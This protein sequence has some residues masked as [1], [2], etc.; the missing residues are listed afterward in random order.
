MDRLTH[1]FTVSEGDRSNDLAEDAVEDYHLL[2]EG[3]CPGSSV[4]GMIFKCLCGAS[5]QREQNQREDQSGN[6]GIHVTSLKEHMAIVA[7]T[8]LS[9]KR[10]RFF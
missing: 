1:L 10:E 3:I 5:S 8:L 9:R 4:M 6:E 7:N 2:D